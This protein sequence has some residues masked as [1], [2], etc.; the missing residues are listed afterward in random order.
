[1]V[2]PE[3][4]VSAGQVWSLRRCSSRAAVQRVESLGDGIIVHVSVL[5]ADGQVELGHAPFEYAAFLRSVDR[6]LS[7]STA[8]AAFHE[9]YAYWRSEYDRGAAGVFNVDVCDV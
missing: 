3:P 4:I 9:G 6:V 7:T 8:D 5:N 2:D 1:M